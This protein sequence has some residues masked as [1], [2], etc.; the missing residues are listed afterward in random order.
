[1]K[2]EIETLDQA[3]PIVAG[4]FE[5]LMTLSPCQNQSC[6]H[7]ATGEREACIQNRRKSQ[8]ANLALLLKTLREHKH[9]V[10]V[11]VSKYRRQVTVVVNE[12]VGVYNIT[13][14]CE[15]TEATY[16]ATAT[17]LKAP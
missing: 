3:L 4:E 12:M 9:D 5:E 13:D 11:W 1:M 2:T 7:V 15:E 17:A 10:T 14:T 8:P 6:H 16:I